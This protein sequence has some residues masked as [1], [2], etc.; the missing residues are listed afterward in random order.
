MWQVSNV[1]TQLVMTD[2]RWASVDAVKAVS[3]HLCARDLVE[4]FVCM[5]LVALSK[6]WFVL[7]DNDRHRG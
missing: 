2:A 5:D 6:E 1:T 7:K 4:E 3:R